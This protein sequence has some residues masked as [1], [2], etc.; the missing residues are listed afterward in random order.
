MG[1]EKIQIER[2]TPTAKLPI[3]GHANDAGLDVY[4]DETVIV[5]PN[6]RA[7]IKTGLKLAVPDGY[8]A[9]V[10]DKGGIAKAGVHTMAGVID[11]GSRGEVI[12]NLANLSNTDY[13]IKQGEKIAQ[14]LIQEISLCEVEETKIIDQTTRGDGKHGSTG[15]Y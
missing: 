7:N 4:A 15:L 1:I 3:R 13:E 14:I 9:L 8:V 2:L 5:Q 6:Q 12:I 11:A 10:W